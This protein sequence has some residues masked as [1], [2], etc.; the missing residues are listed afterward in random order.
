MSIEPESEVP[1]PG[2][3]PSSEPRR[4]YHLGCPVWGDASW[5]GG[6]Y[7]TSN[8]KRWLS[9]Y[10]RV[11]NTVEGNSTFY[12]LPAMETVERW[13]SETE[14]GFE[15]ALKVPREITHDHQLV[16]ADRACAALYE[17]L[18]LLHQAHRLGPTFLQLP[19]TFSAQL[20]SHLETFIQSWPREFPLSIEVRHLDYFD[21]GPTENRL[22]ELL[23]SVQVDRVLFDSRCLFSQGPADESE[24]AAQQRK[25]KSPYRTTVTG[26]RP[27]LRLI[28]RNHLEQTIPWVQ[29]WAEQ[30][31]GWIR[32][33]YRP[34][35]FTH[36]PDDQHAP[37]M[38]RFFHVEL[39]KH[40]PDLP[41]LPPPPTQQGPQQLSLF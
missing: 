3:A 2:V 1:L 18:D 11:F 19:P 17:R 12:A 34:L 37:Q 10:S 4:H 8:R 35:V 13:A 33:G 5:V 38:A 16:G 22:N 30:V 40:L 24:M 39:Q 6:F 28:G 41:D 25:P 31:A 7:T 27:F 14:D 26:Q 20:F 36:T 23:S 21:E 32:Q 29:S 9:E 15:F